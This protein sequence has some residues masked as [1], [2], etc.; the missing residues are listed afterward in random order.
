KVSTRSSGRMKTL[1]QLLT[2]PTKYDLRGQK[3]ALGTSSIFLCEK[4][5]VK[6]RSGNTVLGK[7]VFLAKS[8]LMPVHWLIVRQAGRRKTKPCASWFTS[9]AT[10]ISRFIVPTMMTGEETKS[11]YGFRGNRRISTPCGMASFQRIAPRIQKL[12]LPSSN[13]RLQPKKLTYGRREMRQ[14]GAW[15]VTVSPKT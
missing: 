10:C 6:A 7:S 8:R 14:V 15:R 2:G 5:S 11:S 12:S 9:L 13:P 4:K 3:L 1:L